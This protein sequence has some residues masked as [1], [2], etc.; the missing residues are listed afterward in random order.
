MGAA[1]IELNGGTFKEA[2]DKGG[3]VLVDWW[4]P[5]CGPCRSFAPI[6]EEA[7]SK[8]PEITFAKINTDENQELAQAFEI[9]GIP[10]LMVFREGILLHAQAGA[11]PAPMLED[12]IREAEGLNMDEVRK[13]LA[14]RASPPKP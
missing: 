6:Y 11:M 2:I 1:T 3:I 9:R 8:H 13:E 7:A 4:A 10:T 5:W 14:A 12:V